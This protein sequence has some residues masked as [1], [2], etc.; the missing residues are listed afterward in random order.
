MMKT[1]SPPSARLAWRHLMLGTMLLV[2]TFAA[3]LARAQSTTCPQIVLTD[4]GPFDYRVKHPRVIKMEG[5]HFTPKVEALIIGESEVSI[6]NDL[7]FVLRYAPNHHRVLLALTRYADREKSDM[8]GTS[9]FT[10]DCHFQRAIRFRPDDSIVRV[11][12]GLHLLKH[13]RDKEGF[14]QLEVASV[15]QADNPLSQLNIGLVYLETG[16]YDR[17]LEQAHKLQRLGFD[18]PEL[19]DELVKLGKWR[20]PQLGTP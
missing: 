19:K 16:H 12:Y 3:P 10:V 7:E 9:K 6:A 18:R 4:E 20:D 17:A 14:Q 13:K 1:K 15:Q 8:P 2:A 11:M 5:Y